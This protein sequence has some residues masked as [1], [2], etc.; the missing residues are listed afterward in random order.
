MKNFIFLFLIF[1]F[2]FVFGVKQEE[3]KKVNIGNFA[4]PGS[5]QPGPLIGFGQNIVDK[6]TFILYAYFDCLKG[7]KETFAE[8][9]PS[10][11][12]G[13]TDKLSI[14][15]EQQFAVEL[16]VIDPITN[17]KQ[18]SR[19]I[20]DLLVQFEYAFCSKETSQKI[21]QLTVVANATFPT[22]SVKKSPPT[23]LGAPSFFLGFTANHMDVDWYYFTS[24]GSI[25]T[26]SHCNF[27]AGSSLLY[28]FGLSKNLCYKPDSYILNWMI[29]LDGFYAQ[30]DI[31]TRIINPN[32][33]G[34]AILLGPSLWFST[35]RLTLQGGI[36]WVIYQKLYGIQ[37]KDNFYATLNV[38]WTF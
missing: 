16:K 7:R 33:G 10:I 32:S 14:F 12:Y 5:Q 8:I 22:G 34:N 21:E 36:S 30:S 4:L 27:K 19:G 20:E 15:V 35:Q 3:V 38:G 11:L 6:G 13:I 2:N 1:I 37:N 9:S 17:I 31:T 28:Q 25:M 24:F 23:G 29:E 18:T 26:T